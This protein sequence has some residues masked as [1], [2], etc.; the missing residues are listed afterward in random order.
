MIVTESTPNRQN[1]RRWSEQQPFDLDQHSTWC[2]KAMNWSGINFYLGKLG[3][4][5]LPSGGINQT[6]YQE[7]LESR[8]FHDLQAAHGFEYINENYLWQQDGAR[9]HTTNDS[10]AVIRSLSEMVISINGDIS[11]PA[12]SCDLSPLDYFLW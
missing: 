4:Y 2:S 6:V 12:N 10:I 5:W 9:A 7:L 11:W 1:D 8:V 3:S